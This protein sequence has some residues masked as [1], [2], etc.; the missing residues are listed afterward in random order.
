MNKEMIFNK[1]TS[2]LNRKRDKFQDQSEMNESLKKMS[3]P[4][5]VS[6][7]SFYNLKLK[8]KNIQMIFVCSIC[9]FIVV[10]QEIRS[11]NRLFQVANEMK[12]REF[13]L[14]PGVPDYIKVRPGEMPT[15]NVLGFSEWFVSQYMDFYY[16]DIE[17][18]YHQLEDYMS[19][20]YREQFKIF[21]KK[22]I[23][24]VQDLSVSQT[25][26]FDP[27]KE[28]KRNTEANGSTYYTVTYIG[29]TVRYTNDEMLPPS[30]PQVVVLKFR[31]SKIDTTKIWLFEVVNMS[32]MKKSE[33]DS[34]NKISFP[35][36][37]SL[38][39]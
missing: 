27:A 16:G 30:E 2:V 11:N 35:E 14:V 29:K 15:A 37:I 26:Q 28:A 22:Q 7:A 1:I 21:T 18:K 39:K 10:M 38:N 36:K 3:L 5:H 20:Q 24:E 12:N 4:P 19:P 6:L 13:L 33:Y 25:Y 8:S 32:V 23:K 31:T 9:I 17:Q 34:I